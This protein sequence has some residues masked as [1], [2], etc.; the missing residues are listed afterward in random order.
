MILDERCIECA[1][2]ANNRLLD[3]LNMPT[4]KREEFHSFFDDLTQ[5][6][7]HHTPLDI[8]QKTRAKINS[9]SGISDPYSEEKLESN[10]LAT[11]L[12]KE[13][14]PLVLKS[15]DPFFMA[16]RLAVAGN[17]MDYGP[18]AR[19]DIHDTIQ[20]VINADFA[21]DHSQIL[22]TRIRQTNSV[23]YLGDNAGEIV[24]DKLF[25][26]MMQHPDVTYA[27]RGEPVINDVTRID[28]SY[29]KMNDVARIIDNGYNAPST[30]LDRSSIEFRNA[31]D[32][33]GL[34][35][36]KGQGNL[37]GLWEL[38]DSR[39]FFLLMAKCPV[40]AEL[41]DVP[42]QSFIVFN[43]NVPTPAN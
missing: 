35:I 17:I 16:L 21:I 28:A 24:F 42:L 32:N 1:K 37:E 22:K 33:A 7:M 40:F 12:Y 23:L 26:E 4:A 13:W 38:N 9:I 27:V 34:I 20:K 14:K 15:S 5:P 39:I 8:G 11:Q 6:P 10:Q 19:F 25:I 3:K 18:N 36:S 2:K 43:K 30:I 41:L 31:F 29:V